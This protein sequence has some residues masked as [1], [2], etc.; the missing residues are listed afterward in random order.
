M[1]PRIF[2]FINL[3]FLPVYLFADETKKSYSPS[4]VVYDLSSADSKVL[5]NVLDRIS[6]LQNVYNNDSFEASIVVVIHEEAI[7]LFKNYRPSGL[8]VRARSLAMGEIIKFQICKASAKMQGI[9]IADLHDFVEMV[10]MA[11]A[12]IIKLQKAGYSYI[13]L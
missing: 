12:E 8:M 3:I 5:K 11:D 4:K 1:F 7:P 9:A 2:L 6:M 13:R 10:P